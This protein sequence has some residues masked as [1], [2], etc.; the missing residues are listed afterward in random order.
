MSSTNGFISRNIGPLILMLAAMFFGT[1]L[2]ILA[3]IGN[4][5][6]DGLKKSYEESL[7]ENKKVYDRNLM[8]AYQW[9]YINGA[10]TVLYLEQKDTLTFSKY[11]ERFS[12][13]SAKFSKQWIGN[14]R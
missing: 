11:K 6:I 8:K 7:E 4:N 9:G 2:S 1:G 12:V 10:N 3:A 5:K 14:E 13:D